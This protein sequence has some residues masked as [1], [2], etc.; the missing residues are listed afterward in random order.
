MAKGGIRVRARYSGNFSQAQTVIDS[1][2][3]SELAMTVAPRVMAT[4]RSK[5]RRDTGD[6]QRSPQTE[7][8]T[9]PGRIVMRT[10]SRKVQAIVD[11]GGRAA[12]KP[13]PPSHRGS[14]LYFWVLRRGFVGATSLRTGRRTFRFERPGFALRRDDEGRRRRVPVTR[15]QAAFRRAERIARAIAIQIKRR[16]LPRPGDELRQPFARTAVELRAWI[17][18]RVRA[19]YERG[20]QRLNA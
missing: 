4:I 14:R 3:A 11:E 1:E 9:R 10:F 5:M 13:A 7:I 20:A 6:E 16:G 15:Q 17:E 2:I 18:S 12:G 19:A 8:T